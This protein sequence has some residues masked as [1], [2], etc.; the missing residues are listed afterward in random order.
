MNAEEAKKI[1]VDSPMQVKIRKQLDQ[2]MRTEALNGNTVLETIIREE[3]PYKNVLEILDLDGFT[4]SCKLEWVGNSIN[5]HYIIDW[6]KPK[7]V[8]K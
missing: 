4:A 6:T 1:A 3:H 7:P 2:L 8:R 5:Y